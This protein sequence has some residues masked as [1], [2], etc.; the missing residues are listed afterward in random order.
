MASLKYWLWLTTRKGLSNVGV[1]GLLDHFGTPEAAY[2]AD[3]A[4]S[5]SGSWPNATGLATASSPLETPDIQSVC[6]ISMTL[7]RYSICKGG[8]FPLT[9]R[10][11]SA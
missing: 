11:P 10:W 7:P 9:T 2:F 8:T 1:L 4:G 3:P 6:G 5:R